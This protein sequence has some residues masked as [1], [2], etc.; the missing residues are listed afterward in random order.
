MHQQKKK[1]QVSMFQ[2][3]IQ[4]PTFKF[5]RVFNENSQSGPFINFN[6]GPFIQNLFI[7]TLGNLT[8]YSATSLSNGKFILACNFLLLGILNSKKS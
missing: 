8:K 6:K 3:S 1:D 2:I 7:R 4:F 5:T